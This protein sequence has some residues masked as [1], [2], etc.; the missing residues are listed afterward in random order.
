VQPTLNVELLQGY[1]IKRRRLNL[2]VLAGVL[3]LL[4]PFDV[5]RATVVH[6]ICLVCASGGG[7]LNMGEYPSLRPLAVFV[8]SPPVSN[9]G[10]G[11]NGKGNSVKGSRVA[12]LENYKTT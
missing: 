12:E 11:N 7:R 10:K 2:G 1:N 3:S 9:D 4:V 5:M 8:F 6:Q